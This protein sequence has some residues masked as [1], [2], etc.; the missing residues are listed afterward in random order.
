[1][2]YLNKRSGS[3]TMVQTG[4]TNFE[5]S[6][7]GMRLATVTRAGHY[8]PD[9]RIPDLDAY[10][11]DVQVVSMTTPSVELIPAAEGVLWAKKINDYFAEMCNKYKGRLY[12]LVTLPYQDVKESIKELERAYKELG[13][14]GITMFSNI[15]GEPIYAP[16]FIPIYEAAEALDLPIFVH[17]A[18]P[19]T[20]EALKRVDMPLP[21]F[22]FMLD[23]TMAVTGLIFKGIVERFPGLKIIHPH[24]GGVFPYLVGRVDDSF[25]TYA[26]DFG[27]SLQAKVSEYYRRN[28]Y[29]DA[30]SFHLPA[31]KCAVEFLGADHVMVGT[32][33]A[34]PI[35]GPERVVGFVEDLHL[36]NEDF[37]KI[38][39]RNAELLFKLPT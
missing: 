22:G 6:Y 17:P 11:I 34:H 33:Y 36:S 37:E 26:K 10:G 28:V 3:P 9:A 4:P 7:Q 15:A 35:G 13:I 27:F 31:M 29:I 25:S 38:M 19:I 12:P 14:K 16:K 1:M 2:E 39:F 24:L 8:D 30:I 32:D 21:L 20:T 18:P 5:F 23:T